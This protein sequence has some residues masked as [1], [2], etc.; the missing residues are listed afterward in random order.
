MNL[1]FVRKAVQGRTTSSTSA[2][3]IRTGFSSTCYQTSVN[4]GPHP[5][6]TSRLFLFKLERLQPNMLFTSPVSPLT[7]G[8]GLTFC[9]GPVADAPWFVFIQTLYAKWLSER[10]LLSPRCAGFLPCQRWPQSFVLNV[11]D[12]PKGTF[13]LYLTQTEGPV[14]LWAS[15]CVCVCVQKPS[16]E[17]KKK[18]GTVVSCM[19]DNFFQERCISVLICGNLIIPVC[20]FLLILKKTT[21]PCTKYSTEGRGFNDDDDATIQEKT[22][23]RSPPSFLT[24][25]VRT[26][27]VWLS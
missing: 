4:E 20:I 26:L 17:K 8:V 16:V 3:T 22:K 2:A 5:V 25:G 21:F 12:A 23:S 24:K 9:R 13:S 7:V 10:F 27:Q 19:Y 18:R 14:S 6:C 15:V 11:R 1:C